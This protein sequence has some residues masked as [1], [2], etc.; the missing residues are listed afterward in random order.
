MSGL[1][2]FWR[3][4]RG[5]RH[6]EAGMDEELR[7]HMEEYTRALMDSGVEPVEAERRARV[8]FGGMETVREECREARGLRLVDEF[9]R[10]VRH[11]AR[12]LRKSPGFTA[13]ALLT[14]AVCLGANLTIFAVVDSILLRPLPFPDA[15]R[16]V[17]IYNSYPKAGVERDGSSITNYYERR[18]QIPAFA[19]LS[20]YRLDSAV[21]GE[22]GST[23]REQIARV[24]PEF[25][26][27]LGVSPAMGR[28]F[29]ERETT[30]Q[31]D[32]VVVLSDE[33]WRRYFQ[34]DPGVLGRAVRIDGVPHIVVGV[35]PADFRFLS[36]EARLYCPFASS[37]D[38]RAASQR[39][40]G[41][42]T[43]HMIARLRSEATLALAQ[44]QID[45]QNGALEADNPKARAFLW[46]AGFRSVVAGLQADHVASVRPVLVGLQA[47][48]LVLLLIGAVNLMNLLLV[49]AHGRRK[50]IAVRQALGATRFHQASE[51]LVE[52]LL[53]ALAGSAAGV[54]AG[55]AGIRL[56]A[57]FG[58]EQLPVGSRV[59][60]DYRVAAAAF[61]AAL[62]L[63]LLL[64]LPVLWLSLRG[65][66][67]ALH[68]NGRGSTAGP[69]AQRLR[70][71]FV[72]AQ[73]ALALVLLTGTGLLGLSLRHAMDQSPGFR[74]DHVLTSEILVPW[75]QYRT[76]SARLAFNARMLQALTS[77]P[78]IV[79]AGVINNVPFSGRSGKSAITPRGYVRRSGEAP[80][81]HYAYGA[82]G[83]YFEAM[84]L[85]LRAG[86]FLGDDDVRRD[87]RVCVVDDD[88]AQHYWP[89]RSAVGQM[90]FFGPDQRPDVEAFTVVGV[91]G[92]V[93][94]EGL[95][96]REDQGAVYFPY[97]MRGD[98][99]LYA[100]V[101]T[102]RD[103]ESMAAALR[104]VV[105]GI[106]PE[107][108]VS[109]VR[110]MDDRI[111]GSLAT[112]RAPALLSGLFSMVAL[113][114][115]GVG[116]YGVLSYA[117]SQR[118]R[119]IGLRMA[120]GAQPAR[121]RS[122]FL[123]LALRLLAAGAGTGLLCAWV[124]GRAM[125]SLLFDV[126][127][128]HIGILAAA[129]AI[130][131]VVT[132]GACLVPSHRASR[133]SPLEALAEE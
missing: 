75:S 106:D 69:G 90:L 45:A 53:L 54:A 109:D 91:V 121:I 12:L 98:D 104:T 131:A 70:H 61:V 16:L 108:P 95:T 38:Q 130:L 85:P 82:D 3:V 74:P 81:G 32:H 94:Q 86:R 122:E 105:Q 93:K 96:E 37:P 97:A 56:L 47:G 14:I 42:N 80:R 18:G 65:H 24:T 19:S 110:S 92:V 9:R 36:V 129:T 4:L 127:A 117:V 111:T 46:D 113:L 107:L 23:E 41:G 7:F 30:Y 13:A 5:R 28:A 48:A 88:F 11:A 79:S 83:S 118:R 114:L 34:A 99:H 132:V 51:V 49:R 71:T 17:T 112:Y 25:F 77:Q 78:G 15:D 84:G 62:L 60:F 101:R 133:V 123:A 50:E 8:E 1:R 31:T 67:G 89:G 120:L 116:T 87:R 115:I 73:V 59:E 58:A 44:S 125:R 128:L 57:V 76:W 64:A 100:V 124:A 21:A 33:Y 66:S 6:F 119:E 10:Q 26:Q 126:P 27:T 43:K 29:T 103:P 102:G 63:G 22:T 52:T 72:V 55:A 40:A 39:H 68:A 2:S 35:L 20:L